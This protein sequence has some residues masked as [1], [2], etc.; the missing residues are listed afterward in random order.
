M[1]L[2][3][4]RQIFELIKKSNKILV[5]LPKNPEADSLASALALRLFL[6][7]LQ[8]DVSVVSSGPPPKNMEFLPGSD[9]LQ[10]QL[11]ARKSLVV[12]VDTSQKKLDEISYQTSEAKAQIFLKA[13]DQEF[14]P[15]DVSFTTEKFP[16][17][18]IFSLGARSLEELGELY[19]QN[20]DLFFETPKINLDNRADNEYFGQIN[21]VDITVNSTAE[22]LADLLQKYEE[23]LLDQDIATCLLL[24]IISATRSF[25]HVQTTPKSFIK[26]SELVALGARQQEIIKHIYKTK[27]LPLLKLWGRSL[28]RMKIFEQEKVVYSVLS[29]ADFEKAGAGPQD[30]LPVLAEFIDNVSGYNIIALL[31][32]PFQNQESLILAISEQAPVRKLAENLGPGAKI[33]NQP[34]SGYKI[35]E[36][37]FEAEA[38]ENLEARLLPIIK[39]QIV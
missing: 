25:Q 38:L 34:I 32:E 33:L 18:L 14:A 29:A 24:G 6:L 30:L 20:T 23:Q 27:S 8:K 15:E 1:E 22:I 10:N 28:A 12:T 9:V 13:K 39:D 37:N 5:V 16:V 4:D 26:A 11:S 2:S 3:I 35:I 36:Q 7:K 21:L 19:E 31:A 17:D